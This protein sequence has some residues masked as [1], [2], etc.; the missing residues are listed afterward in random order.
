MPPVTE[1]CD[2]IRQATLGLQHAFDRGL[3]H[4]DLK[5][6]NLMRTADGTVKILDFGLA[7]M[8]PEADLFTANDESPTLVG[9]SQPGTLTVKASGGKERIDQNPGVVQEIRADLAADPLVEGRPVKE[10]RSDLARE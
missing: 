6:H 3:I 5:P 1:A 10:P 7:K 8:N 9:S 2:A 4:R